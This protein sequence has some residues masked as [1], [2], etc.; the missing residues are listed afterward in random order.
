MQIPE[1]REQL[2]DDELVAFDDGRNA[3]F[4]NYVKAATFLPW[5]EAFAQPKAYYAGLAVAELAQD[6]QRA[7]RAH[8][9]LINSLSAKLV[10]R[11]A[12]R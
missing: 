1:A 9:E 7:E 2:I 12:V 11:R 4:S 10:T 6:P 5:R 3:A 8:A